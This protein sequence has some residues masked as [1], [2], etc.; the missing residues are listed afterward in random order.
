MLRTSHLSSVSDAVTIE[1]LTLL[2]LCKVRGQGG[3]LTSNDT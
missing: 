2:I 1:Q 3:C